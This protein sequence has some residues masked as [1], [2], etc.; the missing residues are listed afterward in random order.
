[1]STTPAPASARASPEPGRRPGRRRGPPAALLR[2]P[3]PRRG[4]CRR[5]RPP[6]LD[7][8][9]P[10]PTAASRPSRAVAGWLLRPG[11]GSG[12][13]GRGEAVGPGSCL[14]ELGGDAEEEVFAAVGGD[15]LD[16]DGEAVGG[17]VEG[18]ADGGLAGQIEGDRI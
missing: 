11:G 17:L 6:P 4:R 12:G 1:M 14:F 9:Q 16:A 7:D 3:Q 13:V 15:E 18:E 10:P 5:Q 8:R 2:P